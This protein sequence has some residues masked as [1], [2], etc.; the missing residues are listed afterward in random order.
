M[1]TENRFFYTVPPDDPSALSEALQDLME[2]GN[3]HEEL[4]KNALLA[5]DKYS[6][7]E[8]E[9]QLVAFVRQILG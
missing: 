3:C 2:L 7:A 1:V 5:A 9:K 4:E 6:W 8:E